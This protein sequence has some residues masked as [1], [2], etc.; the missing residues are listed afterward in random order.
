MLKA[1]SGVD[2]F[3]IA[4]CSA[5]NEYAGAYPQTLKAIP[6]APCSHPTSAMKDVTARTAT[7][8]WTYVYPIDSLEFFNYSVFPEEAAKLRSCQ[9]FSS[10]GFQRNNKIFGFELVLSERLSG[11]ELWN[12]CFMGY[13]L[14]TMKNETYPTFSYELVDLKPATEYAVTIRAINIVIHV[15]SD[16]RLIFGPRSRELIIPTQ[17]DVPV[18]SARNLSVLGASSDILNIQWELPEHPLRNGIISYFEVKITNPRTAQVVIRRTSAQSYSFSRS[19]AEWLQANESYL[20]AVRARTGHGSMQSAYGPWT[21]SVNAS[22]CPENMRWEAGLGADE[23]FATVGYF[24]DDNVAA[25]RCT[26]LPDRSYNDSDCLYEGASIDTIGLMPGFWRASPTSKLFLQCPVKE[27]C[28]GGR[29]KFDQGESLDSYCKNNHTG[30]Y[31]YGCEEGFFLAES[32]CIECQSEEGESTLT[33]LIFLVVSMLLLVS[34]KIFVASSSFS[35]CCGGSRRVNG[36]GTQHDKASNFDVHC[37]ACCLSLFKRLDF[38]ISGP[39]PKIIKKVIHCGPKLVRAALKTTERLRV[40]TKFRVL[41]GFYQVLLS[42]RMTFHADLDDQTLLV[43]LVDYFSNFG[44]LSLLHTGTLKCTFADYSFYYKLMFE[45]MFPLAF[46]AALFVICLSFMQICRLRA[47]RVM[48]EFFNCC[49]VLLFLVYPSVSLTVFETFWCETFQDAGK[50]SAKSALRADYTLQCADTAERNGWI[51]YA[52]FMVLVYPVGFVV[53]CVAVLTRCKDKI[54]DVDVAGGEEYE[55]RKVQFLIK[56]YKEKAYWF[57]VYELIRKLVQVSTPGFILHLTG[58]P[59]LLPLISQNLTILAVIMVMYFSPYKHQGDENFAVV[60]LVLLIPAAQISII[61][62]YA[63]NTAS[64]LSWLIVFEMV[65]FLLFVSI[66]A[67][68]CK[69]RKSSET[70]QELHRSSTSSTCSSSEERA[71]LTEQQDMREEIV[72]AS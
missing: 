67:F 50:L 29:P 18:L 35:I 56:P 22:T 62:G 53:L 33:A 61:D 15:L 2:Q 40:S 37:R 21:D 69:R 64:V 28:M 72:L 63:V 19:N 23:C 54:L 1:G 26:D 12:R 70:Y 30:T 25:A 10:G 41:L 17:N 14:T 58:D 43:S 52:S 31:C 13:E 59:H 48:S 34:I 39:K 27:F 51:S 9:V 71:S 45:T 38:S 46:A 36:Q 16:A 47:Q 8:E 24:R 20:V 44:V 57:E 65:I 66:E 6:E 49:L 4:Q 3:K 32:G 11:R 55:V 60:S 42:Y 68:N 5:V 7:L